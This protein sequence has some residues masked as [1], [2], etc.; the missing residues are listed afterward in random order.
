MT[1]K[2]IIRQLQYQ[3]TL[4]HESKDTVTRLLMALNYYLIA[5]ELWEQPG[6]QVYAQQYEQF[7]KNWLQEL[8]NNP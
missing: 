7:A 4:K 5:D 6:K 1:T 3:L 2:E 8:T